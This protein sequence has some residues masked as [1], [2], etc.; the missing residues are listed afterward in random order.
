MY[1]VSIINTHPNLQVSIDYFFFT[2]TGPQAKHPMTAYLKNPTL[3]IFVMIDKP[4]MS[5]VIPQQMTGP[6]LHPFSKVLFFWSSVSIHVSLWGTNWLKAEV[7]WLWLLKRK[8]R[9][10]TSKCWYVHFFRHWSE[11]PHQMFRFGFCN[12]K[13]EE[14]RLTADISLQR[15]AK[16]AIYL[17]RKKTME[18]G[19]VL[20]FF[21]SFQESG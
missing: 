7:Y 13:K 21:T 15:Q 14:K 4:I 10:L 19:A 5:W 11:Q 1:T 3:I 20:W 17:S 18:K 2:F 8:E 9:F 16:M 12:G 6:V